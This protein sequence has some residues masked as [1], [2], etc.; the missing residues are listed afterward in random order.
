LSM[1]VLFSVMTFRASYPRMK[2]QELI[3]LC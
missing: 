1:V 3:T 2:Y